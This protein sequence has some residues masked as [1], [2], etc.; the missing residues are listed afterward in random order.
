MVRFL[1]LFLKLHP[2]IVLNPQLIAWTSYL[3]NLLVWLYLYLPRT[4]SVHMKSMAW[5]IL[6]PV[7]RHLETTY[8][9]NHRYI[10]EKLVSS[11]KYM[12]P[13]ERS[14]WRHKITNPVFNTLTFNGD[15]KK[16]KRKNERNH[17]LIRIELRVQWG[18]K[19][20]FIIDKPMQV[21]ILEWWNI[22]TMC[23][24]PD[25]IVLSQAKFALSG[26]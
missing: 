15:L 23:R 22:W 24:G 17:L 1:C 9:G 25:N 11:T 13:G 4:S 6:F 26:L 5:K 3:E 18:A 19:S 10:K 16:K 20:C 2:N 21:G 8:F 12:L 7:V 14:C